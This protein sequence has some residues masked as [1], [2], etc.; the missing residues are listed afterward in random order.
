[1]LPIFYKE[2]VR[3]IQ[4]VLELGVNE[5]ERLLIMRTRPKTS[6]AQTFEEARRSMRNTN[7]T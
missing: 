1:M 7:P 2:V 5:E 6:L 4:A 3:Q